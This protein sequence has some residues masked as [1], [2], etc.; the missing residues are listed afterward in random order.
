M[1]SEVKIEENHEND[2]FK[3]GVF[4]ACVFLSI[5]GGFGEGFGRGLGGVWRLCGASWAAFGSIFWC[6]YLECSPKGLLEPPGL[7]FGS[8]LKG[9]EGVRG[10]V[11]E[12]FGRVW[13]IKNCSLVEPRFW[14]SR[15]GC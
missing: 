3:N 9:L 2:A 6:L 10:G 4:F 7:D 15:S 8:I 12:G 1:V 14:I 13:R 11:W 5:L